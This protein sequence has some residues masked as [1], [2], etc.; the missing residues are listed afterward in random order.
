MRIDYLT[1]TRPLRQ[2]QRESLLES[3]LPDL[4]YLIN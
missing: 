2:C 1:D 3:A 4:G